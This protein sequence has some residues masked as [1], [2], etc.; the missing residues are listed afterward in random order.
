MVTETLAHPQA[1]QNS[2]WSVRTEAPNCRRRHAYRLVI[3]DVLVLC[4]AVFGAA[5]L[6]FGI[7][8]RTVRAVLA[9]DG[10]V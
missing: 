2:F 6:S 1:G 9:K 7:M 3:T 10:A 5:Y 4:W 8:A